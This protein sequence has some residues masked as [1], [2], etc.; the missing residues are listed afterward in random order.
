MNAS[1]PLRRTVLFF[2]A[3]R[4]DRYPSAL[5]SGAD[6]VCVDLEDAVAPAQKDAARITALEILADR[7]PRRA[8]LILR[9]NSPRST[10]GLQDLAA[11]AESDRGPDAVML[12]KLDSPD[13]VR[14]VEALLELRHPGIRLIAMIETALGLEAAPE[15]ARA[16]PRVS[17]LLIGGVDLSTALRSSMDWEAMLYARSRVVHAAATAEIDAIDMPYRDVPDLEGLD[18][19]SRAARRLGLTGR[20]AIHPTQV[21]VI[22]Q[23]FSPA[24]DEVARAGEIVEAYRRNQGGVLLVN[25][26]LVERPVILA[27]ERTLAIARIMGMAEAG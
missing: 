8:E 16:T 12:P 7:A 11:L 23:A 22:Q 2:P 14:W 20:T 10:S 13:E 17:A 9:I 27:A 26:K 24:P 15:I 4:P 6:A 25:G 1:V 21:P 5:A 19:E 3:T 18:R